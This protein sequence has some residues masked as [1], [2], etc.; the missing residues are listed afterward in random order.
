MFLGSVGLDRMEGEQSRDR[1]K[2]RIGLSPLSAGAR[3]H[4]IMVTGGAGE[5]PV[6]GRDEVFLGTLEHA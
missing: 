1:T 5:L 3:R 4:Q 2:V 6:H